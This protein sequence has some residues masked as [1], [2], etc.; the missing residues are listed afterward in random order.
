MT[1][2][3]FR[4]SLFVNNSGDIAGG[5]VAVDGLEAYLFSL[6]NVTYQGNK[7]RAGGAIAS[8]VAA[9]V[10]VRTGIFVQ[11]RFKAQFR[12]CGHIHSD[13]R[14]D[15]AGGALSMSFLQFR[16][17]RYEINN[18]V[19][20]QNTALLGGAIYAEYYVYAEHQA[21]TRLLFHDPFIH[22]SIQLNDTVVTNNSAT[23][24]GAL[25]LKSVRGLLSNVTI[26]DNNA[27]EMGGACVLDEGSV[28]LLI[29][30]T[31]RRNEAATGGAIMIG[32]RSMLHCAGCEIVNN[33]ASV[34]GGGMSIAVSFRMDQSVI[35]Q[36][37]TCSITRNRARLGGLFDI[38]MFFIP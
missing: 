22:P 1:E 27:S 17:N 38:L 2:G 25:F 23:N 3:H 12:F 11:N 35:F 10:V 13:Y 6:E 32:E 31:L 7:A 34:K 24:G 18:A 37:E 26:E 30:G 20:T 14:A 16:R 33:T 28:V 8:V 9:Q 19:L 29:N 4:D 15:V 36:C 21:D 5:A